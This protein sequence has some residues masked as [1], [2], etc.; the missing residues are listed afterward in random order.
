MKILFYFIFSI[1]ITMHIF[2][3]ETTLKMSYTS[4]LNLANE[5]EVGLNE[6]YLEGYLKKQNYLIYTDY[7]NKSFL[8][9]YDEHHAKVFAG[10]SFLD[11]FYLISGA[12]HKSI[13]MPD[14]NIN[15]SSTQYM[16]GGLY[17]VSSL[18]I[19]ILKS[20]N[21][22]EAK[23]N[24]EEIFNKSLALEFNYRKELENKFIQSKVIYHFFSNYSISIGW[25]HYPKE[26][27]VATTFYIK[28]QFQ[29]SLEYKIPTHE[30]FGN[31]VKF[32]FIY[33]FE[34]QNKRFR[35]YSLQN[36]KKL[37]S[38]YKFKKEHKR[39]DVK[40]LSYKSF[41]NEEKYL[42]QFNTKSNKER[43]IASANKYLSNKNK[44][45]K[46][47]KI[48]SFSLLTSWGLSPMQA[49][50]FTKNKNVCQL[51]KIS[52]YILQKKYIKC[53]KGNTLR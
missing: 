29:L 50:L 46:K 42:L 34:N 14:I 5:Q 39:A 19:L 40:Q 17:S 21:F 6:I 18:N 31:Q 24:F 33:H 22:F 36:R 11:N 32:S 23:L 51:N 27:S 28:K 8:D 44:K 15:S 16:L 20:K 9:V 13:Q 1:T 7:N 2:S 4:P 3:N 26:I 12:K 49:F 45:F 53:D 41:F 10:I 30:N 48:P 52:K 35:N 38:T 25:M 47:K 43:L 37:H